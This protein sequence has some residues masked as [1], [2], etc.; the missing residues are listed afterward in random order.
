MVQDGCRTSDIRD[1]TEVADC[2]EF[3]LKYEGNGEQ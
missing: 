1:D 2:E 3:E